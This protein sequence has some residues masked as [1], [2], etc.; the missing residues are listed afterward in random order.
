MKREGKGFVKPT[1]DRSRRCRNGSKTIA[2]S[3]RAGSMRWRSSYIKL[4][5]PGVTEI[6]HQEAKVKKRR[7]GNLKSYRMKTLPFEI[8]RTFHAPVEKVWKALTDKNDMKQWYFDLKAFKPEV[9]FEFVFEAG[10]GGKT[11]RH[12]CKVTEVVVNRKLA[13]TWRYDG[14]PGNSVV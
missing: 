9:G 2:C 10:E 13:Y 5:Q 11:F 1:C 12:V 4:T 8:E 3:G 14:Y 7:K 6:G